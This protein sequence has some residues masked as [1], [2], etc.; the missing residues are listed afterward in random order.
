MPTLTLTG[1]LAGPK[2]KS[3]PDLKL[4]SDIFLDSDPYPDSNLDQVYDHTIIGVPLFGIFP[5]ISCCPSFW[6]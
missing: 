1:L 4:D 2:L 5:L 3:E 6:H